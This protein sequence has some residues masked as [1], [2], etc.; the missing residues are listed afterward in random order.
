MKLTRLATV[1]PLAILLAAATGCT[2][3]NYDKSIELEPGEDKVLEVDAAKN[4]QNLKVQVN[5]A[6]P[7]I[8]TLTLKK[9][10][11]SS[12]AALAEK[13]N[14]KE[15]DFEVTVPGGEQL[16]IVLSTLKKT[17]VKVKANNF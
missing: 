5:S 8:V 11:E 1:Y 15:A 13:R 7:I 4:E 3:L 16:C 6:E 10:L 2:R 12:K 9:N 14:V 17:N